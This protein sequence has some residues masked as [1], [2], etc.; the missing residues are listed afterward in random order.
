MN[1]VLIQSESTLHGT[2]K[3]RSESTGRISS[4]PLQTLGLTR[5]GLNPFDWLTLNP[6]HKGNTV[7]YINKTD[8][9][10][11]LRGRILPT[12]RGDWRIVDLEIA[13]I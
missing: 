2:N 9:D 10:F 13:S 3:D 4:E 8:P 6:S 11:R 1:H 5:F 12:R 7:L